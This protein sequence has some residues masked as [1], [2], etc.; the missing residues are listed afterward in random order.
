MNQNSSVNPISMP[1]FKRMEIKRKKIQSNDYRKDRFSLGT[2]VLTPLE[3]RGSSGKLYCPSAEN[4][5]TGKKSS[6]IQR[7][8]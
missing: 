4:K 2:F 3:S 7:L 6:Q 8:E 1:V 5:T